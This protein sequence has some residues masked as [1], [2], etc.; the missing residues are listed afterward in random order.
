MS[1][2][3]SPFNW[4]G[5]HDNGLIS[6]AMAF[7]LLRG[8]GSRHRSS[9]PAAACLHFILLRFLYDGFDCAS[10][11]L[12]GRVPTPHVLRVVAGLPQHDRG[13]AADMEAV[14]A[15][16]HHR[17][18]LRQL[19]GPF[20]HEVRVAPGRTVHDVL[21]PRHGVPRTSV[22]DLHWLASIE[23]LLHF[24]Y[25]HALQVAELLLHERPR[26]GDLARVLVPALDRL[27]VDVFYERIDVCPRVRAKV[28]VVRVLVHIEREDGNAARD[29]RRVL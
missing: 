8:F 9:R 28:K 16:H 12:P 10:N 11:R 26:R 25:A 23:H 15:E 3:D 2:S 13:L 4:V 21:L 29:A 22:D 5:L 7:A 24:L 27:P 1:F 6:Y 18:G 20:L 14:Y 17:V 19:A